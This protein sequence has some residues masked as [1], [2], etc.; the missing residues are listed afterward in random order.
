[1]LEYSLELL[2]CGGVFTQLIRFF[3]A[4]KV[5][6]PGNNEVKLTSDGGQ[7]FFA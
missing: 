2:W 1:M 7:Y 3:G 5:A 6:G 4:V